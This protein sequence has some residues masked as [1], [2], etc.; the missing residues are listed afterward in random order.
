MTRNSVL[1]YLEGT[2]VTTTASVEMRRHGL[3]LVVITEIFLMPV[4]TQER[5][6]LRYLSI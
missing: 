1:L 4:K 2:A 3:C 6:E 5:L